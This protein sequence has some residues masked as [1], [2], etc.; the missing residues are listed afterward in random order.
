MNKKIRIGTRK[1]DLSVAQTMLAADAMKAVFPDTEFELVCRSTVGDQILDKPL[2]AFGGKGVFVSEFEEALLK[3]T[4]DF[5][6]HSAKDLPVDLA[7][8]LEIVG[9]L[10][11]GDVRDVLVTMEQESEPGESGSPIRIGTSSLRRQLQIQALGEKLWPGRQVSCENLR[12]N[13]L[14]RLDQLEQG[15]YDGIILAAAGLERLDILSKRPG[16]YRF[17]Y[18][19][20]KEMIPAAGQGILVIEGR[21]GDEINQIAKAV[22][23]PSAMEQLRAE[24]L[25][26]K[27]LESGC[28]EPVGVYCR[29]EG[30][31]LC[32]TG[33]YEKDGVCRREQ[34]W[35]QD[36][37]DGAPC[38]ERAALRLAGCL[39]GHQE[40]GKRKEMDLTKPEDGG[41]ISCREPETGKPAGCVYLVG[42]G[43]GDAG[44]ITV[45]G[46]QLLKK[47]GCV[48]Y[49][50]LASKQ[51]L[52]YVSEDCEKIFVGKQKGHHSRKQ[53]EINKILIEKSRQY[54]AVVRLKGGDPYVFGRGGEEALALEAAGIPFRVVPGVTSAI[55]VPAAAGIPITHRRL[56]RGFHVIT[57]HTGADGG[58]PEDFYRLGNCGGTVV[59]LMGVS[60]LGAISRGLTAQGWDPDTPAAV[61]QNGTLPDQREVR[62]TLADI[63]EKAKA[64]GIGTP[65]VI[66]AGEAAGLRLLSGKKCPLEGVRI[67]ITGT[68]GF[69][70]RLQGLLESLGAGVQVVCR[71][72]IIPIRSREVLESYDHLDEYTWLVF[73]SS[74][75]VRLYLDGLLGEGEGGREVQKGRDLRCLGKIKIAVIGRGTGDALKE[76]HLKA[77][78]MPEVFSSR[79]LALGLAERLAEGD[80]VLIPR[81][82]Q[83][84]RELTEILEQ[85]GIDCCDLPV[86]DVRPEEMAAGD[87]EENMDFLTFA[88]ASG[89][90]SYFKTHKSIGRARLCCIGDATA[91]AL[92]NHGYQADCIAGEATIRGLTEKI[93]EEIGNQTDKK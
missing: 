19:S 78:Y 66:V 42:A 20:A 2:L 47:C 30:K 27:L 25:V 9:V 44:L 13:V 62:G 53:E 1:S 33:I 84:A 26:L 23:D 46:A 91:K 81:A 7:P 82:R 21:T 40:P 54:P 68:D 31:S 28:H 5:A 59:F 3:G 15:R 69:T 72:Q 87:G 16:R 63:E 43:P 86:Y 65:A 35:E 55:A 37:E 12:G 11:R 4:I 85:A 80:R 92:Q 77:D 45:R 90:A 70:A 73:T 74:N 61:I 32:M 29:R 76:Y 17:H 67:G 60:Q 34:V 89:V 22:S 83:G 75:G 14:T 56:S 41:A 57:G 50:H 88:S 39:W 93:M 38:W 10:P 48:V 58:L 18:L 8:G 52:S 49:D 79:Q 24:R 51:L 6:V 36:R 71:L 64:A